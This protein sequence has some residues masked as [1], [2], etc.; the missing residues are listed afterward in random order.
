MWRREVDYLIE[1][2]EDVVSELDFSYSSDTDAG[3]TNTEGGDTLLAE[4]SVEHTLSAV[5]LIKT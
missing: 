5:L 1:C 3:E 4:R 2:G